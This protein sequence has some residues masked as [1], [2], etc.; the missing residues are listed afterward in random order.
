[1]RQQSQTAPCQQSTTG[2]A[3]VA[4]SLLADQQNKHSDSYQQG[5]QST[6]DE[7]NNPMPTIRALVRSSAFLRRSD[8]QPEE[9]FVHSGQRRHRLCF[10]GAALCLWWLRCLFVLG[11]RQ[12]PKS[13]PGIP[14]STAP[15]TVAPGLAAPPTWTPGLIA[16]PT[17]ADSVVGIMRIAAKVPIIESLP[18][19]I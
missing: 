3:H 10:V 13:G 17:W 5:K 11:E 7:R 4:N 14:R 2:I 1:M 9:K 8:T 6:G 15:R 19:I 12:V 16:P 18:S